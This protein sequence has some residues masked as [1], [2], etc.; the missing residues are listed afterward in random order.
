M[1]SCVV[2][3]LFSGFYNVRCPLHET[4]RSVRYTVHVLLD[5]EHFDAYSD[6]FAGPHKDSTIFKGV[7]RVLHDPKR[8]Q[9]RQAS[10]ATPVKAAKRRLGSTV[11]TSRRVDEAAHRASIPLAR[12]PAAQSGESDA[13]LLIGKLNRIS[14]LVWGEWVRHEIGGNAR[15]IHISGNESTSS[16][17]SVRASS[18]GLNFGAMADYRWH[19]SGSAFIPESRYEFERIFGKDADDQFKQLKTFMLGESHMR[20]I[21]DLMYYLYSGGSEG[22]GHLAK[23]HGSTD[24]IAHVTNTERYHFVTDLGDLLLSESCPPVGST[25]IYV[26]QFGSWD[27]GITSLRNVMANKA[28]IPH[29]IKA[30]E[31]LVDKCGGM[32]AHESTERGRIHFIW[33]SPNPELR[34]SVHPGRKEYEQLR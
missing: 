1:S 10:Q 13:G 5:F 8:G 6:S 14:N 31:V 25:H 12:A 16:T 34:F 29:L 33:L 28:N 27:L 26:I 9:R 24:H 21:W 17:S 30:V 19:G 4:G 32:K 23:K 11:R 2:T 20:Y 18:N 22:L 3:D 15:N 7:V